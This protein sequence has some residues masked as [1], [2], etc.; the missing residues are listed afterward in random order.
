[1]LLASYL[2]PRVGS[3]R[4]VQ[5]ALVGYCATGPLIGLTGSL[6]A[7]FAA[8][9]V[10]GAFQGTLDVAMNTQAIA[11][12]RTGR[13]ALMSGLHGSW[14]IG[15]FAG[16]G[17]GALAVSAGLGLHPGA[18]PRQGRGDG[19]GLRVGRV[20]VRSTADRAPGLGRLPASGARA[21]AFPD[22]VCG[23][24]CLSVAGLACCSTRRSQSG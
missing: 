7:L 3:R 24:G 8:L 14:S 17:I 1:M 12:E 11:V 23:R 2:I 20:R 22:G 10:W 16:A 21:A 5:T 9:F 15:S 6:A 18:S 19:V 4:V 13:R